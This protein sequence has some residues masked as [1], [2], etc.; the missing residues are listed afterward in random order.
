VVLGAAV[1]RAEAV[2]FAAAV[3]VAAAFFPVP[4][5]LRG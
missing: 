1:F 5:I 2:F 3:F 4:F